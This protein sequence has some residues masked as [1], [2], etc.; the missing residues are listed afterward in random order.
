MIRLLVITLLLTVC[1]TATV[2]GQV[3]E[4]G[5]KLGVQ[6]AGV[7]SDPSVDERVIGFS[8]YGFIDIRLGNRFFSTVDLGFTRRGFRNVQNE[9]NVAG[10]VIQRVEA[11]S[12][13][14]YVSLTPL[15]NVEAFRNW[16]NFYIG[17]GPRFDLLVNRSPGRYEFTND[18]V[19]EEI[20]DDFD[21]YVFGSTIAAGVKNISI[22]ELNLRIE[23]NYEVDITD[24]FSD[25]PRE[26]RNNVLML[27]VGIGF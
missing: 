27:V 16:Q 26:F 9:T 8:A 20:V 3:N 24:S 21:D 23:A 4:F 14:T 22:M 11:T 18:T 12:G 17:I 2:F 5:L 6:S 7:Y 13:L 1:T 10:E 19:R 25:Y 15:I